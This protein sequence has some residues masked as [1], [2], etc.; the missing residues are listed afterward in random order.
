MWVVIYYTGANTAGSLIVYGPF[1]SEAAATAWI[2]GQP[3]STFYTATQ[4]YPPPPYP[5]G[6]TP[7]VQSVSAGQFLVAVNASNLSGGNQILL[8]G[9][10]AS[11]QAANGYLA[12]RAYPGGSQVVTVMAV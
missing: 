12:G 1:S 10:F 2:A 11:A 5:A 9:P 6:Q 4:V 3:S 7:Q 8:Y